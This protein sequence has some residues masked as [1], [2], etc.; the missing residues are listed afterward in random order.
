MMDSTAPTPSVAG[1]PDPR[2]ALV[3]AVR[4]NDAEGAR[5]LLEHYPELKSKLNQPMPE[6][7]FGSLLLSS[8]VHCQNREMIDL[9]LRSGADI[10]ARSHWWAG[11]F[12]VLDSCEPEFAPLLIARGAR[13][14]AHAAARLGLFEKLQE[15][16]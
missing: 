5:A 8:A 13:V 16:V 1:L 11:S 12:G 4:A 2:A 15:L 3:A 10:N 7:P 14:D 9:L 6:L